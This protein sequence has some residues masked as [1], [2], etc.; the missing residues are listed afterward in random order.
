MTFSVDR[1]FTQALD[2]FSALLEPIEPIAVGDVATRR[3]I[4]ERVLR[5]VLRTQPMPSDV[6]IEDF[7]VKAA[8]GSSM[9]LRWYC[10]EGS[11]PGSAV[12]YLHGGGLI[13]ND[14]GIYDQT[15]ANYV[16]KSGIPFLSV[17]YRK[18][19][20]HPFPTP[21]E[22]CYSALSWL[23]KNAKQLNVDPSRLAVMGDSA[24]GGLSAALTILTRERKG[25]SLARQIL[26]YPMLD[27]RNIIEDPNL[28]PLV[29]WTNDDNLTA[30]R[31]YLGDAAGTNNVSPVAAPAHL[32]NAEGLP[33]A[34]IEVGELDIFRNEDIQYARLLTNDGVS[35]E[36]HL[37]P[38]VIHAWEVF[39][40]EIPISVRAMNDRIRVIQSF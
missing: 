6:L 10:K 25:P 1:D 35:T 33:P 18:A 28:A 5:E 17:D 15:V 36:F 14:V 11:T 26:I 3:E 13:F 4:G 2:R 31:A 40:P 12:L 21:I 23:H 9:L 20:E 22:D 37:R 39:A 27:D 30:W 24:G 32:K 29:L 38:G 7:L 16:S 8:D 19:P 34:Y